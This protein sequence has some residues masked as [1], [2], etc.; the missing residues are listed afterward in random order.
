MFTGRVLNS[1]SAALYW[2]IVVVWVTYV[3]DKVLSRRTMNEDPYGIV[4]K[5]SA[6]EMS[7]DPAKPSAVSE[8]INLM[9]HN[10]IGRG[11]S[12]YV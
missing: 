4:T 3:G 5:V 12:M 7:T 9:W 8:K 11:G 6:L 1:S 2:C 10:S